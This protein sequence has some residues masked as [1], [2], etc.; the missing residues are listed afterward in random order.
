MRIELGA[1]LGTGFCLSGLRFAWSAFEPLI[2]NDHC[3][4]GS[5]AFRRTKSLPA[6]FSSIDDM[7]VFAC[8]F[9]AAI[10][11][12]P[13]YFDIARKRLERAWQDKQSELPFEP[14]PQMVQRSLL[15][16]SID[17]QHNPASGR[18]GG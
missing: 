5:G 12:Q 15:D 1:A 9:H 13:R 3:A 16:E 6:S 11:S 18:E 8:F 7:A 2:P 14:E 10:I 4:S 17:P